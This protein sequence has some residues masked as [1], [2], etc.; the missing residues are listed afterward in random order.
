[1]I[2]KD[3]Q[4]AQTQT[5]L[6]FASSSSRYLRVLDTIA[7]FP[8]CTSCMPTP[9]RARPLSW[10]PL[11]MFTITCHNGVP[12]LAEKGTFWVLTSAQGMKTNTGAS[13]LSV[14]DNDDTNGTRFL[15]EVRE[16]FHRQG[17]KPVTNE[18]CSYR[19]W[20]FRKVWLN[21]LEGVE[22]TLRRN[23]LKERLDNVL[24][25]QQEGIRR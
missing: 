3:S 25:L 4:K 15:R 21:I 10:R 17:S 2:E 9:K 24:V 1:M 5:A 12:P 22:L 18:S 19:G 13:I 20:I 8:I 23:P 11:A 14:G 16:I 6:F 7:L